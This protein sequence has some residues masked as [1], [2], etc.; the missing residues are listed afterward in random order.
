[1]SILIIQPDCRDYRV[2]FFEEL[3]KNIGAFTIMH[4][5]NSKFQKHPLI[6][7]IV[8]LKKSL[9][10]FN[11]VINLNKVIK[12]H[13]I[14]FIVN[15]IHW[16]NLFFLPFFTHKKIIAWGHGKSKSWFTNT[17]RKIQTTRIESFIVYGEQGRRDLMAI[18]VHP[19]K[20]YIAHN[21]IKIK[22]CIDTSLNSKNSFLYVGRLQRRKEL[23]I[24]FD[25]FN[26][27]NLK[28]LGIKIKI[29]GDGEQEKQFLQQKAKE[30]GI[31]SEIEFFKGT[32]NNKEL[33]N[34]FRDALGYISPGH[35]GLGVLHSFAYGVPVLTIKNENH[36]PEF[37]N[38]INGENGIVAKDFEE[39]CISVKKF[40]EK[41]EHK[42]LGRNAFYHY[43]NNRQIGNMTYGFEQAINNVKLRDRK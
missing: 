41:K 7:E 27:L 42:K 15:D 2:P 33:I 3:S 21:T 30:L 34:Y 22:D 11:W 25:V 8:G 14:V 18:G 4:F 5:G 28:S 32:T 12:T 10:G 39:Y 29:V 31:L 19:R 20:I 35:V 1:M 43:V 17:I 6:N 24:F 38:I 13:D 9:N 16:I 23:D 37:H 26:K 36:A 40:I